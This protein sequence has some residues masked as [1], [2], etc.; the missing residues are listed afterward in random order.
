VAVA[1]ARCARRDP[2]VPLVALACA[3]PAKFPDAVAAAVG[4]RPPV[5]AR[6]KLALDRPERTQT[7]PNE[8]AAVERFIADRAPIVARAAQEVP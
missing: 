5:P 7:L 4:F 1:A 8:L 6:L 2:A 3:H